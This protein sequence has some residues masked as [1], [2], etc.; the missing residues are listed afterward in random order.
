MVE[1]TTAGVAPLARRLEAAMNARDLDA[2]VD[3]FADD[4]RNETPAH[5]SRGFVGREQVRANWVQ[6]LGSV[7]DLR[8]VLV[9]ASR[10]GDAEW[11]EWDW[12]GTR[13][14]GA[15]LAM[16]GVTI[17]GVADGRAA[18]A[19]FYMEPVDDDGIR[20]D[21]VVRDTVGAA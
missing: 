8:A 11:A 10:D 20:V 19:R 12:S 17:T 4:Y 18:W 13:P 16:R 6:I 14:D 7:P 21:E 1:A 9:R 3:C 5:P 2:L 15:A